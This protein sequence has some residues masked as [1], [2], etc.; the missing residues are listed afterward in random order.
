MN[1]YFGVSLMAYHMRKN[2]FCLK[3]VNIMRT[4]KDTCAYTLATALYMQQYAQQTGINIGIN[5]GIN[6][7]YILID[8]T[9]TPP[10]VRRDQDR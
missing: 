2:S 5:T 1:G 4:N 9:I 7:G 6:I 3:D 10:M 8:R